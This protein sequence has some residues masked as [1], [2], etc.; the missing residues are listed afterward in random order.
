MKKRE[1]ET[2]VSTSTVQTIY[3]SVITRRQDKMD[4]VSHCICLFFHQH[5][6]DLTEFNLASSY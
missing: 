1:S 5:D 2:I 3:L 6:L 4:G